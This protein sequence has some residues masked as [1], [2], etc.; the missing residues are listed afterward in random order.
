MLLNINNLSE[1]EIELVAFYP[2]TSIV[3]NKLVATNV[4]REREE[5]RDFI[6]FANMVKNKMIIQQRDVMWDNKVVIEFR[7]K[8]NI[9]THNKVSSLFLGWKDGAWSLG[10]GMYQPFSN[11][12][13]A[14]YFNK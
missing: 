6:L 8:N 3:I 4:N 12:E 7:V 10:L 9:T 1:K 14:K 11:K 5:D 2:Y 13:S